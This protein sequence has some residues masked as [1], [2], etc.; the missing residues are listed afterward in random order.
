MTAQRVAILVL[1]LL[2]VLYATGVGVG[3]RRDSGSSS[4]NWVETL[5]RALT[6]KLDID[7]LH[8]DCVDRTAKTFQLRAGTPCVVTVPPTSR[9]TRRIALRLT[10]GV[11]VEGRYQAPATHEKIDKDDE[12]ANQTVRI[13]GDKSKAIV[14]LKEGGTV[15]LTCE[16]DRDVPC[17]LAAS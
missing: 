15:A 6:P 16:S 17:K 4:I 10:S 11:R 7:T 12:S 9:G 8:G 3:F 2:A 5:S 1:V 13:E 14:I